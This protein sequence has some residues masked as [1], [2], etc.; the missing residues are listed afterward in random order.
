MNGIT[1]PLPGLLDDPQFQIIDLPALTDFHIAPLRNPA[2]SRH[3]NVPLPLEPVAGNI[4]NNSRTTKIKPRHDDCEKTPGSKI[5][6]SDVLLAREAKKPHLAISELLEANDGPDIV[7]TQLPSFISLSVVEKSPVQ[8][9]S[10]LEGGHCHKR[11]RLDTDNDSGSLEMIRH[12]PRPAQKE[13][14]Q[15]RPAPLLPAMVTGASSFCSS[16]AIY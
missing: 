14:R 5:T 1:E 15:N 6:P 9:P 3:G 12:L 10:A 4:L 11:L 13:D 8:A 2:P 16:F 7:P